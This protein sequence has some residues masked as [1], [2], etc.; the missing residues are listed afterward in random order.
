M[1]TRNPK[2]NDYL[3]ITIVIV[4]ILLAVVLL[5][6]VT[7]AAPLNLPPR[8][9][10]STPILMPPRPPTP[11]PASMPPRPSIPSPVPPPGPTSSLVDGGLIELRAQFISERLWDKVHW[12]D[13][14][15]VVQWQDR[16]GDWHNVEGWQGTFDEFN[17]SVGKKIWWVA[18]ADFDKGPF[19]WAIYQGKEGNLLVPT[20]LFYLPCSVDEIV[21][22][23][24]LFVP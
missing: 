13:L 5:P 21:I 3:V 17:D 12:Q 6:S 14:W 1:I 19:R 9:P 7:R 2:S 24:V 4:A 20:E 22:V 15:V 10:T 18:K 16:S 8:P 23:E 11:T